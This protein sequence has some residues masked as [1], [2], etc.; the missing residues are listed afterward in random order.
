MILESL[1]VLV[2]TLKA[3]ID[4][5]GD[6]LR[7]SEA[8]TRYAL[9]DPLLREL[10]WDTEDPDMVW[11]EY[12]GADYALLINC[13]SIIVVESKKLDEPLDEEAFD[14]GKQYCDSARSKYFLLTDGRLWKLYP[15]NSDTPEISFDLEDSPLTDV[16]R[17][18]IRFSR[19]H[20]TSKSDVPPSNCEWVP[21]M[22][23]A[24]KGIV[25]TGATN[26]NRIELKFPSGERVHLNSWP[27]LITESTHWLVE[28][29]LLTR[30]S[31]PIPRS[32]NPNNMYYAVSTTCYHPSGKKMKYPEEVS[33]G[34][35]VERDYNSENC[36]RNA[37]GIIKHA[38]QDPWEFRVRIRPSI[39]PEGPLFP[40]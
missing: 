6:R 36:V 2:E 17:K 8:L 39:H 19:F 1:L 16:C 9:I 13:K 37:I 11:P 4:E 21:L 15:S 14:Q 10:G 18:A 20:V 33:A 32:G 27:D 29:C 26:M 31:L 38:H 12:H 35:W 24:V 5:Y 40:Q 34:I 7:Q 23:I 28:K 22:D 30:S 25:A 3:R